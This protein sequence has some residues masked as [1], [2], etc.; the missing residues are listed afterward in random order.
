MCGGIRGSSSSIDTSQVWWLCEWNVRWV[1]C[2]LCWFDGFPVAAYRTTSISKWGMWV[3]GYMGYVLVSMIRLLPIM[4]TNYVSHYYPDDLLTGKSMHWC[5]N[6]QQRKIAQGGQ[7]GGSTNVTLLS[8]TRRKHSWNEFGAKLHQRKQF[9]LGRRICGFEDV[10]FYE[11]HIFRH[12]R[13]AR[14]LCTILHNEVRI[15]GILTLVK[16]MQDSFKRHVFQSSP[17]SW[18]CQPLPMMWWTSCLQAMTFVTI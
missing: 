2:Y 11:G 8:R 4:S 14:A 12:S 13:H 3:K 7:H 18:A 1:K 6:L 9:P 5:C 10:A 16:F 15:L 17:P